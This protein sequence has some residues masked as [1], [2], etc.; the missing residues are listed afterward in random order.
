MLS[1]ASSNHLKMLNRSRIRVLAPSDEL[2]DAELFKA[3]KSDALKFKLRYCKLEQPSSGAATGWPNDG[4]A[5]LLICV[6]LQVSIG[7]RMCMLS[8]AHTGA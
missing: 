6:T 8:Q 2:L 1:S 5:F 7:F 4:V 3:F